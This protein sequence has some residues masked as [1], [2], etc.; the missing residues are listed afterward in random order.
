[1]GS[2]RTNN[3][4]GTLIVTWDK[5]VLMISDQVPIVIHYEHTTHLTM[6]NAY[7]RIFRTVESLDITECVTSEKN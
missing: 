7:K 1:M 2:Q 4:E 6:L 3:P 5:S